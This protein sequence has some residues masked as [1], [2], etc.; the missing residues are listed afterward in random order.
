MRLMVIFGW[1]HR[2][3]LSSHPTQANNPQCKIIKHSRLIIKQSRVE[4]ILWGGIVWLVMTTPLRATQRTI[5]M[6]PC[7]FRSKLTSKWFRSRRFSQSILKTWNSFRANHRVCMTRW[8]ISM[9]KMASKRKQ[10]SKL[11]SNI[12]SSRRICS[13]LSTSDRV[14]T[15]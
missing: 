3:G 5:I 1:V 12:E 4:W 8:G 2:I 6:T 14:S 15:R 7:V 9:T 11:V 13:L 10:R